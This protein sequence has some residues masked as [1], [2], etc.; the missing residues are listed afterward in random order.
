MSHWGLLKINKAVT[1]PMAERVGVV[2]FFT[3]WI[4]S[5][6]KQNVQPVLCSADLHAWYEM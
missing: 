1:I 6:L 3:R 4:A 2:F 5:V